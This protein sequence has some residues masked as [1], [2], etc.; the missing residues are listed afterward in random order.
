MKSMSWTLIGSFD[1]VP[2]NVRS[3]T[4]RLDGYGLKPTVFDNLCILMELMAEDCS[5]AHKFLV[6]MEDL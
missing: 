5:Y 4:I 3:H 6:F 1:D 2:D